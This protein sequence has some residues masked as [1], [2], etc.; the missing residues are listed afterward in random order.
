MSYLID[1]NVLS[2][3]RKGVGADRAVLDWWSSINENDIHLSVVAM[4]EVYRGIEKLS[5]VDPARGK[6]FLDWIEEVI[7]AFDGRIIGI[8][9]E[10]A[11]I[12]GKITSGRSLPLTDALL[13]ATALSRNLTLVTRNTRD[14]HD[15]GVRYLNPFAESR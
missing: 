11:V 15:T 3:I 2:E 12:W 8:D 4:G 10:A 13:A 5:R 9:L 7:E 6:M 1:T 14:I